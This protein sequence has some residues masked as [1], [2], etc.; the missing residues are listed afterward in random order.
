MFIHPLAR[1]IAILICIKVIALAVLFFA[2]FGPQHRQAV[3]DDAVARALL[4]NAPQQTETK[5]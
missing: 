2:F 4:S 3:D 1:E 5:P